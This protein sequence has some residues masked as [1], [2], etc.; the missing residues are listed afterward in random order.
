MA[1]LKIKDVK[2]AFGHVKVI[3]G[4]DIDIEDGEFLILV[5]P[6]GC[7]KSTLLRMIAGLEETTAGSI[8]LD[9]NIINKLPPR[10]RDIAMVFQSYAL[11]P[12]KTVRKNMAFSLQ[13][14]GTPKQEIEAKVQNAAEVL[15]LTPLLERKPSQLSGGQ[16]QRVAMGRAIVRNPKLF[17]FDEPLSNLDAKLRVQMRTEIKELHQRIKTTTVYVTHDQVEAMTMADRIVV[18]NDGNIEQIGTPME[19]YDTP[20]TLFVA[21]FIGSPAMNLIEGHMNA[22]GSFHSPTGLDIQFG[23][24]A[25]KAALNKEITI[26]LRPENISTQ[27]EGLSVGE[28]HIRVV[29]PTGSE[30]LLSADLKGQSIYL[31]DRNRQ[32]FSA[33]DIRQLSTIA[34]DVHFFDKV[35]GKRLPH[36]TE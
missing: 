14:A 22:S 5:G 17:L 27:D 6:S 28:A 36:D 11:Y 26:G 24:V 13:L 9:D 34:S 18:M 32:T 7:G 1:T 4:V 3:H 35:S 12:H 21:S 33:G 19:L 23:G 25:P 30:T 20:D 16:R 10:E 29:E 8:I 31:L 2:K 15:D